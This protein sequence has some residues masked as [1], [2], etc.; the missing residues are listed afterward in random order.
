[1]LFPKRFK[2]FFPDLIKYKKPFP[3]LFTPFF[4]KRFFFKSGY[5]LFLSIHNTEEVIPKLIIIKMANHQNLHPL[6]LL[7]YQPVVC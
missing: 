6:N 3:V 4:W 7:P 5:I 1:M 2:V